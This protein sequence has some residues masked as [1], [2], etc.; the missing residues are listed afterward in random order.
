MLQTNKQYRYNR[1]LHA[2]LIPEK[3]VN[4]CKS[5]NASIWSIYQVDYIQYRMR[6]QITC[7]RISRLVP[8]KLSFNAT[9]L[10][11]DLFSSNYWVT[12]W[13]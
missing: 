9:T 8:G 7:A 12:E 1:T 5:V 11:G 6:N 10:L 13:T 2:I 4:S 3:P